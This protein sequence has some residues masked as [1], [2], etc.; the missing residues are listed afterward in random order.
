MQPVAP[1]P[2]ASLPGAQLAHAAAPR[3]KTKVPTAQGVQ[4]VA[5]LPLYVPTEHASGQESLAVS[6]RY[7]PV[8]HAKHAVTPTAAENCPA[9][10]LNTTR[11]R[12]KGQTA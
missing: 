7:L 10:Q 5:P 4:L 8:G 3:V 2:A 12:Q 1:R 9:G 11:G 6:V